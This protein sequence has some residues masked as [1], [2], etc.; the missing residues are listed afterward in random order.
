MYQPAPD[1]EVVVRVSTATRQ[2]RDESGTAGPRPQSYDA[3]VYTHLPVGTG[4]SPPP[5]RSRLERLAGLPLAAVERITVAPLSFDRYLADFVDGIQGGRAM[6][7]RLLETMS[8]GLQHLLGEAPFEMRIWWS[9]SA[10]ELEDFPWELAVTPE[11]TRS[12]HRLVFLRGLPPENP[13]PCLPVKDNPR[14]AV[15]G[16]PQEWPAWAEKLKNRFMATGYLTVLDKPLREAIQEATAG[17]FEFLHII[18][19]GVVSSALEGILYD[20]HPQSQRPEL[21]VGELSDLLS[22]S[23]AALLAITA[24]ELMTPDTHLVAGRKVLSAYRA[25][26]YI[27]ASSL[28]MPSI[29]APLGP[30]PELLMSQFWE[31][32]YTE[33][34]QNWH[35][36]ESLRQAH[37]RYPHPLPIALFCRHAGGKL[38]QKIDESQMGGA[39]PIK[40]HQELR[41]SQALTQ[42]LS[43]LGEKYGNLPPEV[44]EFL[45]D[46]TTRQG[47]LR[48]ELDDWIRAEE[49][50]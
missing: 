21:P 37:L 30:V 35:L 44:S 33:V 39:R 1:K 10:P 15:V 32:F 9:S 38:F 22:G 24:A 46:Q 41:Q 20:V 31:V 28:P 12:G 40:L 11:H 29:I 36:T 25:F 50:L 49:E 17:G 43:A 23:R 3:L 34:M 45:Q 48:G 8:P 4:T 47:Q 6:R 2:G 26:A 18:A 19:D 14:L 27:G 16:S 5:Q 13:L 42:R 7:Q